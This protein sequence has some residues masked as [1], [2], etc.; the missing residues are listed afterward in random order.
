MIRQCPSR[1]RSGCA[2][3]SLCYDFETW[4]HFLRR[5]RNHPCGR[6]LAYPYQTCFC[7]LPKVELSSNPWSCLLYLYWLHLEPF[8]DFC[9]WLAHLGT[10]SLLCTRNSARPTS[11]ACQVPRHDRLPWWLTLR[12]CPIFFPSS[13][14]FASFVCCRSHFEK[15]AYT[16]S[17]YLDLKL[18]RY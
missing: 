9:Q 10:R 7:H 14:F 3:G 12:G 4:S 13:H 17:E 18:N 8:S 11:L 1:R 2:A 6:W 5:Q 15:R 16:G